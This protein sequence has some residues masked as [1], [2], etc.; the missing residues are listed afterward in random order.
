MLRAF[1]DL[2]TSA[3]VLADYAATPP[4]GCP[5]GGTRSGKPERRERRTP[6]LLVSIVTAVKNGAAVLPRAAQSVFAQDYSNIEYIIIDGG[7]NDGTVNVIRNMEDRID[8]WVSEPD[9]GI[10]DAFN[11][12]IALARGQIIGILN[13]DDWYEPHAISTIVYALNESGADIACGKL[14]YWECD[15]RT[16]LITSDAG[17]LEKAMTVGH[18]TVFVRR[19]WYERLG[20]FRHDFRQAMDYEW[21]L[22]AKVNGV[23]FHLVDHCLANMQGGG[24]G[25][26]RWRASQKEVGL[27]RALHLPHTRGVVSYWS[28]LGWAITKGM[29][30]RA[31]DA[32]GLGSVRRWYHRHISRVMIERGENWK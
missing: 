16:Y 27:A 25:E 3:P 24:I 31:L 19:E 5:Q 22:R 30:R 28:Y 8:L 29:A 18:P 26:R 20:L 32:C 15:H 10:S 2:Q 1:A 17:S 9:A 12:G 6:G 7:S 23:R 14:Q 11:K 4:R 21:L 13:S